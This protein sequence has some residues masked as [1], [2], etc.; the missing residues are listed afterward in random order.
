MKSPAAGSRPCSAD[1]PFHCQITSLP[2]P[3]SMFVVFP[4]SPVRPRSFD[5]SSSIT[6]GHLPGGAESWRYIQ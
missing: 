2:R 6:Q 5:S 3:T 1:F 4:T